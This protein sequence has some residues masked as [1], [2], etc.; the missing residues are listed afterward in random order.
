[1]TAVRKFLFENS[2]D[3]EKEPEEVV[4][5]FSE[6]EVNGAREEGF[7][8]GKEEGIRETA[9][10]T[11]RDILAVMGQ[12]GEKFD[13]LFKVQKAAN[14]SIPE[15]ALSVAVGIARG[16]SPAC[17][18][19]AGASP[20]GPKPFGR[21]VVRRRPAGKPGVGIVWGPYVRFYPLGGRY[22]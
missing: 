22:G 18:R 21:R 2:F 20:C 14:A 1:M 3:D 19:E 16:L 9:E 11:E 12:V 4:P 6:K 15:S 10:A 13:D 7:A 17:L 8:A 5:T